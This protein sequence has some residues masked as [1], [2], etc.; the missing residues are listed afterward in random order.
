MTVRK[1]SLLILAVLILL[2]G[3]FGCASAPVSHAL[4]LAPLDQMSMAVQAAPAATQQSYR[5][6]AANADVLRHIP[7][8]CG[9]NKL[10]HKSNYDCYITGQ[11]AGG[12]FNFNDHALG[13]TICVDITQAVMQQVRE[14]QSTAEIRD[15]IDGSFARYG[16]AN[17]ALVE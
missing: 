5:F 16:P 3:S 15:N 17:R 13:C 14:G 4:M 9:C 10:G 6:A 7:C 11:A 12:Q 8:Y 1:K 2:G